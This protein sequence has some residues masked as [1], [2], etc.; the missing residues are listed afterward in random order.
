M[1]RRVVIVG[2]GFGGLSAA[3]QLADSNVEI[4]LI[5]KTNHHLFQ[6]LL[7]QV[8]TAALSPAD[9]AVP[10]RAIFQ[11]QENIT[12]I[13]SEVTG[14]DVKNQ[15]VT[16]G[17]KIIPFDYL[18]LATGT[19]HSYFKN[20]K[21]EQYAP[22]LKTL[23]DALQIREKILLSLEQAEMSNDKNEREA[24]LNF[25]VVGGGPTGVEM[26]GAIAEITKKTVIK[27]FRSVVPSDTR[28]ILVEAGNR[29]LSS[30]VPELSESAKRTLKQMGVE[31][32]LNSKV[33]D[34]NE[35]GAV[36]NG[37][38]IP[39]KT[40][41]WAAGNSASEVLKSL[42]SEYDSAGRV[43]VRDD[44]SIKENE[45]IFV[46]GDAAHFKDMNGNILPGVAQV[47]IQQGRYVARIIAD[48]IPASERKR[49]IYKDKGSMA[50]IGRGQA[51]ANVWGANF[52]G[53]FAWILWIFIHVF[54]L[55]SFRN[56]FRVMAEWMWFYV[57]FR[58]G[59]RLITGR[60]SS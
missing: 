17:N 58:N 33:E 54:S 23:D 38:L 43:I 1:K 60:R 44:L 41:I 42:N 21:W 28:I 3:R 46:I 29:I 24:F 40:I 51:I 12:V 26:A 50:T 7:Y 14:V 57:T 18:I 15:T 6:P 2:G 20:D 59:V 34:I 27:D 4:I 36:V 52:S 55:I 35:D 53:M 19:R 37:G 16:S 39:S 11:K 13:M 25:I 9:I 8:A 56:R 47:A 49:F 30:Y 31:V 22:G 10:I 48:S 45:N 5:D 32:L